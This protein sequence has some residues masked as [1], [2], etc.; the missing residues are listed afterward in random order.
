MEIKIKLDIPAIIT[1]ACSAERIQ[2]LVDK[3]ISEAIKDAINDATGYRSDFRKLLQSQLSESMPHGLGID[4]CAKFQ[5]VFNRAITEAVHGA[6]AQTI[7]TAMQSALK[8]VIP[9][10]PQRIK[11][12]ELLNVARQGFHKE[13]HEAF[14]AR[15]KLS[16]YGGGWLYLD[17]D[18]GCRNEYSAHMNLAFNK[19]GEVYALKFEGRDMTPKSLPVAVGR[20]DGLLLSMY[21]GRTSLEIDMDEDEV[22]YAAQPEQD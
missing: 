21:V 20:F 10:V 19:E 11:M 9:D 6:N 13:S 22:E 17:E 1:N 16:E 5:Q 15:L 8:G 14:Y 12:T 3:A 2:P 18:D 4:D 7:Q